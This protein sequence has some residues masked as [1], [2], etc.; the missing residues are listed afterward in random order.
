MFAVW[1]D[2]LVCEGALQG[3]T[4]NVIFRMSDYDFF[5]FFFFPLHKINGNFHSVLC[6]LFIERLDTIH[7]VVLLFGFK[8]LNFFAICNI[9]TA[10]SSKKTPKLSNTRG[11]WFI[12]YGSRSCNSSGLG[13][14]K[15]KR[16]CVIEVRLWPPYSHH[17]RTRSTA[18]KRNSKLNN[19]KS[20][21]TV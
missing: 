13:G 12:L 7:F 16:S 18:T 15:Q 21:A 14:N 2:S 4:A 1:S 17:G 6:L 3:S 9:F 5:F 19:R 8:V 11:L 10:L 20:A